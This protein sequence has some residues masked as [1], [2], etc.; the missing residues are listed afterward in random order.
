MCVCVCAG[1]RAHTCVFVTCITS[2]STVEK[3][4]SAVYIL[5]FTEKKLFPVLNLDSS[6]QKRTAKEFFT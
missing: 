4:F 2:K 5:I 6:F 3:W 1:A